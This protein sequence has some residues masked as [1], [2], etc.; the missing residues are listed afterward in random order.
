MT[1]EGEESVKVSLSFEF[2]GKTLWETELSTSECLGEIRPLL[3]EHPLLRLA[4]HFFFYA[5]GKH[6][7]EDLALATQ[8]TKSEGRNMIAI[9]LGKLTPLL[10]QL[11][12]Q[13]F[14]RFAEAPRRY[15]SSSRQKFIHVQGA[16]DI[17]DQMVSTA[18][19][20]T[21]TLPLAEYVLGDRTILSRLSFLAPQEQP[22]FF[23]DL[24]IG[25]M[26]PPS[27]AAKARGE[28]FTLHLRTIEG[29]EVAVRVERGGV[30]ADDAGPYASFIDMLRANSPGAVAQLDVAMEVGD[31]SA[32]LGGA[33]SR[34]MA[35][36]A[37]QDPRIRQLELARQLCALSPRGFVRR[38]HR[39]WNEELQTCLSLPVTDE[40][41]SL[42]R[43]R[44]LGRVLEEFSSA[45][46][47]VGCAAI[48]GELPALAPEEHCFIQ[49]GLFATSVTE[50]A[51]WELPRGDTAFPTSVAVQTEVRNLSQA[52]STG[53]TGLHF[54]NTAC[55]DYRG[56]RMLVQAL[57][58]GI[59]SFDAQRWGVYG[60]LDDGKTIRADSEAGERV[61][62]LC[63]SLGLRCDSSFTDAAGTSHTINGSPDVKVVRGGD[64]RLYALDLTR[65]SPRDANY[66]EEENHE[67]CSLRP[68]LLQGWQTLC[69][70]TDEAYQPLDPS[71]LTAIESRNASH[72]EDLTN[73][74]KPASHLAQ[75]LVPYLAEELSHG[76]PPLDSGEL[77][78]RLHRL[79]V[80][81]RYLGKLV[82]ALGTSHVTS[83]VVKRSV[84]VR[85]VAKHVRN[86]VSQGQEFLPAAL[87][88]INCVVGDG[89]SRVQA[90][91]QAV[92]LVPP[93]LLSAELRAEILRTADERFGLMLKDVDDVFI[94]DSDRLCFIREV[95]LKL[96]IVLSQRTLHF[97]GELPLRPKDVLGVRSHTKAGRVINEGLQSALRNVDSYLQAKELKIAS[98]L[99]RGCQQ[100]TTVVNGVLHPHTCDVLSRQASL[101]LLEGD[102]PLATRRQLVAVRISEHLHGLDDHRTLS[103]AIDLAAYLLLGN[104]LPEALAVQ[105]T[106]LYIV[107]LIAGTAHPSTL[108]V[109]GRFEEMCNRAQ[110]RSVGML[111][112]E[113]AMTRAS[114]LYGQS[115]E[116]LLSILERLAAL[117]AEEGLFG[118]ACLLQARHR[119]I[120]AHALKSSPLDT[121]SPIRTQLQTRLE[122]SARRAEVFLKKRNQIAANN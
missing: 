87:H 67:G 122:E 112:A 50:S 34:W 23:S 89:E 48:E 29:R 56:K 68:E 18:T 88:A 107:Q 24:C 17:I 96:G 19:F 72:Q 16:S 70:L 46:T 31:E 38:D 47:E 120:L 41:Q 114:L 21:H 121:R 15:I 59:L 32:T 13:E 75:R 95:C 22:A 94:C 9:R 20:N 62:E 77:T 63:T 103:F 71:L 57:V 106:A 39:D 69:I 40:N 105:G 6:L 78:G 80:N 5:D 84:V 117:K 97:R 28:L 2:E 10:A 81:C 42:H 86:A 26:I 43:A 27:E 113:E 111:I 53:V 83:R 7:R 119:F 91:V 73:L 102:T 37:T 74:R 36:T 52:I 45:A 93:L 25:S 104:R 1:G 35:E 79:G 101:A 54:V 60:S 85:C 61:R 108:A 66:E 118:E 8:V 3:A 58:P 76:A 4:P 90:D 99:L 30:W 116:R 55:V 82:S 64:G 110:D 33:G 51:K 65:L 11:H 12:L 49:Q 14:C 100:L 92:R 109:L 98:E 44:L 115:D